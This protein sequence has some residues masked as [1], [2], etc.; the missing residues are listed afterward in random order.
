VQNFDR[1]CFLVKGRLTYDGPTQSVS[2]FFS[3]LKLEPPAFENPADFYM[4]VGASDR[5]VPSPF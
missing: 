1:V 2:P 4:K 5:G 3:A